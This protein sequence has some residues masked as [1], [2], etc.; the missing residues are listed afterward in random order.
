M[1]PGGYAVHRRNDPVN[2]EKVNFHTKILQ[3][4]RYFNNK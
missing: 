1:I 3:D 4:D 2:Q